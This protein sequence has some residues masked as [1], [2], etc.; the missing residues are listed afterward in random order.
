MW[1]ANKPGNRVRDTHFTS[2]NQIP[3]TTLFHIRQE[4]F[5]LWKVLSGGDIPYGGHAT[6]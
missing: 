2:T 3:C 6:D 5:F 4:G 1:N